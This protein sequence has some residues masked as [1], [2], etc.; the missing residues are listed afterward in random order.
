MGRS[1]ED[2]PQRN[3]TKTPWLWQRSTDTGK[4][5]ESSPW[6]VLCHEGLKTLAGTKGR[7]RESHQEKTGITVQKV[8]E[9]SH[10]FDERKWE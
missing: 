5:S 8:H 6:K 3:T 7:P 2:S 9:G 10:P 4:G 1:A